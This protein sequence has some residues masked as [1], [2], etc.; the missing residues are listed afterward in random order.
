MTRDS[1]LGTLSRGR[2]RLADGAAPVHPCN[3]AVWQK[4]NQPLIEA[5]LL[6]QRVSLMHSSQRKPLADRFGLGCGF[7]CFRALGK[8]YSSKEKTD[9]DLVVVELPKDGSARATRFGDRVWRCFDA[10][11][12]LALGRCLPH[13][14][15]IDDTAN[16]ATRFYY[17]FTPSRSL[18]H[19]C[20]IAR[21]KHAVLGEQSPLFRHWLTEIVRGLFDLHRMCTYECV[22]KKCLLTLDNVFVGDEG[23][24]VRFGQ[25]RWGP[26]IDGAQAPV[27]VALAGRDA[28]LLASFAEIVDGMLLKAH[29]ETR[30]ADWDAASDRCEG[31]SVRRTF[32]Q[33][34]AHAGVYVLPGEQFEIVLEASA[35][36]EDR[37]HFPE[38][39]EARPGHRDPTST[40]S[41]AGGEPWRTIPNDP[42][43]STCRVTLTAHR[44]G[45]C[46]LNFA[47]FSSNRGRPE[48]PSMAVPVTI[49]PERP[50]PTLR[51][52]L[53]CCRTGGLSI[54]SLATHEYLRM[55]VSLGDVMNEYRTVFAR[56]DPALSAAPRCALSAA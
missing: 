1:L 12:Q 6:R 27:A 45:R 36:R 51:A 50:S 25:L 24:T 43:G 21:R 38:V 32:S 53:R 13:V 4:W 11:R 3:P 46:I 23:A 44:P 10:H 48:Q 41:F 28:A 14:F 34:E 9:V 37:W 42:S 29:R 47:C 31:S 20:G 35:R 55:P 40:V 39:V 18:A 33:T 8:L 56:D 2:R 16:D 30:T 52:I 54:A 26:R 17:A 19:L 5:Q 15:G 49:L 7:G 22:T